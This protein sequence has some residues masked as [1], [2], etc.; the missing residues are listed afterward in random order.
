VIDPHPK[1]RTILTRRRLLG[2]TT[3]SIGAVSLSACGLGRDSEPPNPLLAWP[4]KN[5]WPERLQ[6]AHPDIQEAYHYAA[7]NR[8]TL[9]WFPCTCGCGPTDGH[10]SNFD[11]Y[12]AEEYD[13]GSVLLD[14]HSF[15]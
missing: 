13:D 1:R 2:V 15:G 4:A 11:C 9:Q 6:A 10:T 8:D 5:E 14:L 3:A 12:V 7:V